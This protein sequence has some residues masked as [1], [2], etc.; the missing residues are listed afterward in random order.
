MKHLMRKFVIVLVV[1]MAL[2][3]IASP[4][5]AAAQNKAVESTARMYAEWGLMTYD[6]EI[7]PAGYS[8]GS[9]FAVGEKKN[10][11]VRYFVTNRHVVNCDSAREMVNALGYEFVILGHYIIFDTV[12]TKIQVSVEYVNQECDLAIVELHTATEERKPITIRTMKPEE[13]SET[14]IVTI[15]FPGE[16]DDF[17]YFYDNPNTIIDKLYST[18]QD[19]TISKGIISGIGTASETQKGELYVIDAEIN[20]GNSGGPLV[21]EKG[22][23]LGVNT[24]GTEKFNYAVSSNEVVKMLN[25]RGIKYI[26]YNPL[27]TILLWGGIAIVVIAVVAVVII[28]VSKNKPVHGRA[29]F[30]E[31]GSLVGQKFVLK[32]KTYIGRDSSKCSIVFPSSAPGVSKVHCC[33]GYNGK[34]VIVMDL[35]SKYGTWI[36]DHKLTPNTPTRLHRGHTLYIGSEAEGLMLRNE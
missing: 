22:N 20:H 6:G 34:E 14:N 24:Y 11:P 32:R 23:L 21:D 29:L 27:A 8:T 18:T 26:E 30:G 35:G 12:D 16:T 4:A 28:L 19:V 31:K 1:L 25:S 5:M 15:G 7:I 9:C 17:L 33:V 36:D 10:S 13:V 3:S 2:L